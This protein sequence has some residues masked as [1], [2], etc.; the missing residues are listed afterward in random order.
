[1]QL[2]FFGLQ[3]VILKSISMIWII[4]E[5]VNSSSFK[6]IVLP[7]NGTIIFSVQNV[8][9]IVLKD[10]LQINVKKWEKNFSKLTFAIP[11]Q[12]HFASRIEDNWDFL[13]QFLKEGEFLKPRENQ[14][15][16]CFHC[17]LKMPFL[18]LPEFPKR[19]VLWVYFWSRRN[20]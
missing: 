19:K 20:L 16:L 4:I 11:T 15:H 2:F 14:S 9:N 1:M 3:I 12:V 7:F 18:P 6:S 13:K 5:P 17:N 8:K 10:L